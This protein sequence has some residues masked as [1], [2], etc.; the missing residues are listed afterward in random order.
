MQTHTQDMVTRRACK[1][2]LLAD[3]T[4]PSHY[5]PAVCADGAAVDLAA[6]D[7]LAL[8]VDGWP[9]WDGCEPGLWDPPDGLSPLALEGFF[10]VDGW[11]EF[12]GLGRLRPAEGAAGAGADGTAGRAGPGAKEAQRWRSS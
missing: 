10:A 7:G 12:E 4:M 9:L 11:F 1:L 3:L 5:A 6:S 8:A 2:L